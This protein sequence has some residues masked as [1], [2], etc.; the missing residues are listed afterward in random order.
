MKKLIVAIDGPSGSGKSTLSRLLARELNYIHIDTGAMYRT[1]ALAARRGGIA[2]DDHESLG[3]LCTELTIHFERHDL[4][5]R[6]FLN[7]ED[8]SAVIRTPEM[9]LLTSRVSASPAVRTAMVELQRA[10]GLHGGVVLEGRDIGT[11]VFPA[12]EVKFFLS[13][14]DQARGQRR[15][16]ELRAKGLDVSLEQT[17]AEVVERDRADQQRLLAPLRQPADAVVID[18]TTM[19]IQQVLDLM[20]TEVRARES[21]DGELQ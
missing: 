18:S 16:E 2:A 19:T 10:M 11:V 14:S 3:R 12:A 1:V 4:Q 5:E 21:L 20:L 7:G 13:A 9:S 6:V 8:V 15:Y 17:I